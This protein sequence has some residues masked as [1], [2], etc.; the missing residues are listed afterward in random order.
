MKILID[1]DA[2]PSINLIETVAKEYNLTV[3]IYFD[4]S[5]N[6]ISNYSNLIMV[7]KRSQ[8]VDIKLVN[9]VNIND[10][11]ITSDYGLALLSLSKNA[12]VL[13][14]KGNIYTKD[15]IDKLIMNRHINSKLRKQNKH[16]KGPKKRTKE[17]DIKLIS[18]LKQIIEKNVI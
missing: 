1:A 8:S 15:N 6:I 9:D 7:D 16:I 3:N 18:C 5:H 10:I 14:T 13:N 11:V 4:T 12:N 17:D 2:C